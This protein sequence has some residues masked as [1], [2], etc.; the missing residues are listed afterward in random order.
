M[1]E[2]GIGSGTALA[3]MLI[4][5]IGIQVAREE[6]P[7][8]Y[9]KPVGMIFLVMLPICFLMSIK[10]YEIAIWLT[11]I[12]VL[13][14][15]SDSKEKIKLSIKN[16]TKLMTLN[17][18]PMKK[19]TISV[20]KQTEI[21]GLFKFENVSC[22][23]NSVHKTLIKLSFNKE[24]LEGLKKTGNEKIIK[25]LKDRS[26]KFPASYGTIDAQK[27]FIKTRLP[28]EKYFIKKLRIL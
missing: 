13:L 7:L 18:R 8:D 16:L 5:W 28:Y 10:R 6:R 17:L 22:I 11:I 12:F 24:E 14:S 15:F 21:F 9:L 1:I 4:V 2:I 19:K 3:G 27:E 23:K 26:L 20:S 25:D